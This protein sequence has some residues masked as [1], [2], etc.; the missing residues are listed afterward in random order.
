VPSYTFTAAAWDGQLWLATEHGLYRVGDASPG[1]VRVAAGGSTQV[2]SVAAD[3]LH[4]RVLAGV[5]DS[6]A[7]A[8][9]RVIAVDGSG[10]LL[11]TGAALPVGKES[12]AVVGDRIWVG[13]YGSGTSP[14]LV[15]LDP[16][17]LTVAG[18]S[19][20]S[21][22]VGPGAILWPGAAVLWVRDGG[23]EGLSCVDP[24][25]GSVLQQWNAVQGPIASV[26]GHAV[27]IGDEGGD[28][29][30]DTSSLDLWG[31]CTG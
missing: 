10:R 11:R 27:A 17:T 14:R 16:T 25:D 7:F 20:V 18:T 24:N 3:P 31:R 21:G 19:Q 28:S 6:S 8:G 15:R 23:D 9:V 22:Q 1:P 26:E 13:G 5:P 4:N 30:T 29:G 2:F 12:I